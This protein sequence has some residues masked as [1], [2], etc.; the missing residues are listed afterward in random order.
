[1]DPRGE[2]GYAARPQTR[3]AL[4][5]AA[6]ERRLEALRVVQAIRLLPSLDADDRRHARTDEHRPVFDALLRELAALHTARGTRLVV[7]YL[8]TGPD[9]RSDVLDDRRA[10]LAATAKRHGI[11]FVDLSPTFRALRPDSL[12]L[13]FISRMSPVVI[14][15]AAGQYSPLAHAVVARVVAG[16]VRPLL[17]TAPPPASTTAAATTA[18]AT[19]PAN[20]R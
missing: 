18:A 10:W 4:E 1:M 7:A 13:A 5:D 17:A 11:P 12:D 14:S 8:P 2:S 19:T 20:A 9:V 15:R 6:F 3:D 16:E